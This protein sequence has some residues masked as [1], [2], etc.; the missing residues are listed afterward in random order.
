M[1]GKMKF[2]IWPLLL[3]LTIVLLPAEFFLKGAVDSSPFPNLLRL[4]DNLLLLFVFL[5]AL[6]GFLG[7]FII[8]PILLV[9]HFFFKKEA[10]RLDS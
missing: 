4:L 6:V 10:P 3:V 7:T 1:M 8:L 5:C 9:I 2:F